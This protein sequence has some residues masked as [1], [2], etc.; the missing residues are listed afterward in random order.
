MSD[1]IE[2]QQM[3]QEALDAI[4]GEDFKILHNEPPYKYSIRLVPI[5]DADDEDDANANVN[6][7]AIDL[8]VDIPLEYPDVKP[9]VASI[10]IVKGLG[11]EQKED[12]IEVYEEEVAANEGMPC[13]FAV[14]EA[15]RG[16]LVDNNVVYDGSMYA[17]MMRK[18]AASKQKVCIIYV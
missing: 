7:V 14:S 18:E 6:H 17:Q 13:L 9:E 5:Q 12:I 10:E 11:E 16:W 2:E 3:E 4:F 8:I 1:Q 15:I